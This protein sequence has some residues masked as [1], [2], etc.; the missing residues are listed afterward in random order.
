M[1]PFNR[2]QT[3]DVARAVSHSPRRDEIALYTGNDDNII[4]DL[5]TAYRFNINGRMVEKR[6]VGGLLG[7]WAVW[8]SKAVELLGAMKAQRN[9][10]TVSTDW[11][12]TN[13]QVTDANAV[14]FDAKNNFQGCIPGIHEILRRQGL[15]ENILCLN[16]NETLSPGQA[17]EIGRICRDYPH[18]HDDSFV[19]ANISKWVG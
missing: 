8:T 5:L 12:T 7:H 1:A 15:M 19:K 4:V 17:E 9:H 6:I 2:Y 3:L 14:I 11:F 16:P 13:A 10:E 18:L